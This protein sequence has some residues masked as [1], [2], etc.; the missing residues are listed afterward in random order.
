MDIN[1]E[2]EIE[3]LTEKCYA[4]FSLAGFSRYVI[5]SFFLASYS[6]FL[7][8]KISKVYEQ[9]NSM[10]F[11][12]GH[13][14]QPSWYF[15]PYLLFLSL[16]FMSFFYKIFG[17]K[18]SL[19]FYAG[20]TILYILTIMFFKKNIYSYSID[21][22]HVDLF[23]LTISSISFLVI[24]YFIRFVQVSRIS[25]N[26]RNMEIKTGVFSENVD[27][28]DLHRITDKDHYR[29][30][31]DKILGTRTLMIKSSDDKDKRYIKGLK[32]MDGLNVYNY[33]KA[34]SFSSAVELWRAK[35]TR[36]EKRNKQ[37]NN[38]SLSESELLAIMDKD[39]E[40]L[41]E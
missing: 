19:F 30:F 24:L 35:D 23:F 10:A 36:S 21:Q 28:T 41:N 8:L 29:T 12:L 17:L 4:K 16:L 11:K 6:I 26:E 15:T 31:I 7:W 18:K 14:L 37:K 13:I 9:Y 1:N 38:R 32:N 3:A 27:S 25:L 22:L 33:L 34:H 5:P 20:S 39:K 2:F 40:D